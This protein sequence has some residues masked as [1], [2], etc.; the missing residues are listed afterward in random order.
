MRCCTA[1]YA[2]SCLTGKRV[3]AF[4]TRAGQ[5]LADELNQRR[6]HHA[7]GVCVTHSGGVAEMMLRGNSRV[8]PQAVLQC[9]HARP[10][11]SLLAACDMPLCTAVS[12]D[13]ASSVAP[14]RSADAQDTRLGHQLCNLG[15][16]TGVPNS[17]TPH[18]ANRP[19]RTPQT[20]ALRLAAACRAGAETPR[21]AAQLQART[22][23]AAG[24]L[25][26]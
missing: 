22:C 3:L 8:D 25:L 20:C 17:S 24:R 1:S 10:F 6:A 23:G 7:L 16:R 4:P 19:S 5:R 12:H 13:K 2:D 21:T 14:P 11:L 15:M 9:L 18:A 26:V